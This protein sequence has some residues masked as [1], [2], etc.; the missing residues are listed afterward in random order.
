MFRSCSAR[1]TG[2]THGNRENATANLSER[3][4]VAF[5][6]RYDG[7]KEK[8]VSKTYFLKNGQ[9]DKNNFFPG[10][11]TY[12]SVFINFHHVTNANCRIFIE[13]HVGLKLEV[14]PQVTIN[15]LTDAQTA[16]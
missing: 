9:K 16:F 6:S 11:F 14:T 5:F 1:Y 7:K 10:Y 12:H 2:D 4:A 3:C 15:Y 13:T 8:R